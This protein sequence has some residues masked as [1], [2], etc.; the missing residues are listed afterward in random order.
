LRESAGFE[1]TRF[2]GE[3]L[4]RHLSPVSGEEFETGRIKGRALEADEALEDALRNI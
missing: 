4:D 2:D 3:W 1:R